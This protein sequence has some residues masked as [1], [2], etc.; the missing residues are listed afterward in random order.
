MAPRKGSSTSARAARRRGRQH[1]LVGQGDLRAFRLPRRAA[2]PLGVGLLPEQALPSRGCQRRPRPAT[3][4]ACI[5]WATPTARSSASSGAMVDSSNGYVY[6]QWGMSGYCNQAPE[7]SPKLSYA[8]FA[9]LTAG[10]RRGQVRR[11]ARHRHDQRVRLRFGAWNS[12]LYAIW[13]LRGSRQLT[14]RLGERRQARGGRC[15]QPPRERLGERIGSVSDRIGTP[16]LCFRRRDRVDRARCERA[17]RSAGRRSSL[18]CW[19]TLKPGPWIPSRTR[20]SR[21][22]ASG[23]ACPRSA[24]SSMSRRRRRSPLRREADGK[25]T[26]LHAQAACG[27]MA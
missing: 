10:S 22:R 16:D 11:A 6:S 25:A 23:E 9:T 27:S 5:C 18:P 1:Q 24:D 4:S 19:M 21:L 2:F 20:R 8:A 17:G 15:D 7:C 12:L 13:N 26:D 14:A 3:T